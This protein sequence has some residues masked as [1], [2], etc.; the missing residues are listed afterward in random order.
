[1]REKATEDEIEL[2][3]KEL[4][5]T[6]NAFERAPKKFLV[7]SERVLKKRRQESKELF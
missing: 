4:V 6:F 7:V 5:R 2:S 3:T 1:V